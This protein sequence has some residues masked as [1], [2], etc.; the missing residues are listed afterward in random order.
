MENIGILAQNLYGGGAERVAANMSIALSEHYNVYLFVFDGS[1][2]HYAY[3]GTVIDLGLPPRKGTIGKAANLIKRI[4]L[5]RHWKKTLDLKVMISHLYGPSISNVLSHTST[6]TIS[7][8]H[9]TVSKTKV[10]FSKRS[11]IWFLSRF[12]DILTNV[13][14]KSTQ[15]LI[16]HFSVNPK[17]TCAVYNF[18][19]LRSILQSSQEPLSA[20]EEEALGSFSIK[21]ITCGRL[22]EEK[23]QW[24][25]IRVLPMIRSRLGN[26]GMILIG[27]GPNRNDLESLAEEL[28]VADGVR[29]MG[30]CPN[31]FRILRN[32]DV[33]AL[34]SHYEGMPMVLLE[35]L[36]AGLPVISCDMDSGAREILAPNSD[37]RKKAREL[38]LGDYGILSPECFDSP[39]RTEPLSSEEQL[40][41]EGIIR[42]LID[43]ELRNHYVSLGEECLS[44]FSA[45]AIVKQWIRL[46]EN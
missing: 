1:K 23:A 42:L 18:C 5:L 9:S 44:H 13:C 29:F 24:H 7:C 45:D 26:V 39:R 21:I 6:R 43:K 16:D 10:T 37:F 14:K 17:K 15:D 35:A 40:L 34:S 12:S 33:F 4:R 22:A 38:E 2:I 31:P 25:L 46:I 19:D 11:K 30:H 3:K 32:C 20:N 36:A 41:G 8:I 28:G 27:D